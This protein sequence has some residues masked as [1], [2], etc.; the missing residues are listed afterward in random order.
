MEKKLKLFVACCATALT[1]VISTNDVKAD[2]D[3]TPTT[4]TT[5]INGG[6]VGDGVCGVT[7][8]GTI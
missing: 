6:C 5:T 8:K 7:K 1:A 4:G 3:P 2:P